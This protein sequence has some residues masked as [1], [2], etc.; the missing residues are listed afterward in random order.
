[1]SYLSKFVKTRYLNKNLMKR[2]DMMYCLCSMFNLI[3]WTENIESEANITQISEINS[4][5]LLDLKLFLVLSQAK[6]C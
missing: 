2:I 3:T 1:M 4:D 5:K 6:D